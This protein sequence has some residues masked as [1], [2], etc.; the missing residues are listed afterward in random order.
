MNRALKSLSIAGA[1]CLVVVSAGCATGGAGTPQPSGACLATKA[2]YGGGGT[3]YLQWNSAFGAAENIRVYSDAACT[4]PELGPDGNPSA[5]A[6]VQGPVPAVPFGYTS[7]TQVPAL[8]AGQ[9]PSWISSYSA[10]QSLCLS[11]AGLGSLPLS[12]SL[13]VSYVPD[14]V[15]TANTLPGNLWSC[16]ATDNSTNPPTVLFP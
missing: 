2:G 1:I 9:L 8:G 12:A 16:S 5:L 6:T 11:A 10:V 15:G 14:W 13:A 3:V 4:V 7:W